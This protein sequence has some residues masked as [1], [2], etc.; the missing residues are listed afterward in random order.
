MLTQLSE[1]ASRKEIDALEQHLVAQTNQMLE[2]VKSNQM[3]MIS[4]L[5]H[6]IR[7]TRNLVNQ[8]GNALNE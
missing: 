8:M 7:F 6:E 2:Q 5:M 3:M 1:N 4:A